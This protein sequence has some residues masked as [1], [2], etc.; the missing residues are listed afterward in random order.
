[1]QQ[2]LPLDRYD[3]V[4]LLDDL[5]NLDVLDILDDLGILYHLLNNIQHLL[6][7]LELLDHHNNHLRFRGDCS[8]LNLC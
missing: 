6:V 7:R 5:G 3:T 1:M 8:H 2:N 4:M